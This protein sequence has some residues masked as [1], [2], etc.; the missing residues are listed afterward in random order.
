MIASGDPRVVMLST[1]GLRVHNRC[2]G[3][4]GASAAKSRGVTRSEIRTR[5]SLPRRGWMT[6][7]ERSRG[8]R[9]V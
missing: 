1:K 2:V 7:G 6:V 8:R 4:K 5:V 3:Q 9:G